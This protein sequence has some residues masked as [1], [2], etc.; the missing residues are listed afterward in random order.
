VFELVDGL[1]SLAELTTLVRALS[2][3]ARPA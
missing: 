2:A 3:S 1:E